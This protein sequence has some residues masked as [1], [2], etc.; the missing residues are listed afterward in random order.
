MDEII[1]KTNKLN[2][3]ENNTNKGALCSVEGSKYENTVYNIVINCYPKLPFNNQKKEDLGGSGAKND[4]ICKW[5]N[6]NIPIEIKKKNT[7][8]WM[9]CSLKYL[10]NKWI[11][12][13]KNKIPDLS[14]KIFQKLITKH[15]DKIFFGKIPP[16]FEKNIT[17]SEW[18]EIKKKSKFYSGNR[19]ILVAY[20]NVFFENLC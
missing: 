6:K 10:D 4:I 5:F 20:Q 7:P 14:K 17:H 3:K 11:C 18:I 19:V 13:K 15:N 2:L 1:N 9:Q 12:S 8:D 16:F